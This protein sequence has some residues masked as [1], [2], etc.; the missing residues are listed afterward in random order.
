VRLPSDR[1]IHA[2]NYRTSVTV[3][4]RT[5]Q[6]YFGYTGA[7]IGVAV[8]D[9]GI[10][11]WHDDLTNKTAK[12]FPYGNQRVSK[13]VDFIN[14]RSAPYDDNGHGT[15]VAGTVAG[16]G[17]DSSGEKS[18]I[19]PSASLIV[20]KVLDANGQGTIGN[21][22]AAMNWIALNAK[23]YNIKV[24][25]LSVGARVT[26]SFWTDPLTIAAK[27]LT[28]KGITVVAAAGNFGKNKLGQLQYGA[29]TAPGN[30]PWVLTVGAS[31][32]N[33][34]LTRSDDTLAAFSSNG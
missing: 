26:E 11:S 6:D 32:T 20:L 10:A 30:A 31:S 25:N 21:I 3:G 15:H 2:H 29:I 5:V 22:I 27:A 34:T 7:G 33:G 4:A 23:T 18:G 8:I 16:N 24:V 1:P 12:N 28:D 14:G 13:F 17:Y 19:A 9:T